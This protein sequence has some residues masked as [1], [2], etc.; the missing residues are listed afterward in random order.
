M[1]LDL[2][3]RVI[4]IAL[5]LTCQTLVIMSMPFG[6]PKNSKNKFDIKKINQQLK[7]SYH[8]ESIINLLFRKSQLIKI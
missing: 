7:G 3:L 5:S 2:M 6:G 1:T 8:H 4:Y